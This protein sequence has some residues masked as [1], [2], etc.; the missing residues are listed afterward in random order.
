MVI[1]LR[2]DRVADYVHEFIWIFNVVALDLPDGRGFTER[3]FWN[4]W[5]CTRR[6]DNRTL[7]GVPMDPNSV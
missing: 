7:V 1:G 6:R 3:W 5:G 2:V 4:W